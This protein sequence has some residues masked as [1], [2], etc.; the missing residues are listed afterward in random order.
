MKTAKKIH[1]PFR[2]WGMIARQ[3]SLSDDKNKYCVVRYF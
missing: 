1:F 3:E 2:E